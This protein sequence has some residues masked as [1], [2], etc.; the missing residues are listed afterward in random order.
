VFGPRQDPHGE[1]GVVAIFMNRLRGE[2]RPRIFGDG[3]Q[4]RDYVY[5]VDAADAALRALDVGGGVFNVGTGRETSVLELLE[6]IQHV[7]GTDVKPEFADPRPG[8]L[9]RSVLDVSVAAR[10]LGWRPQHDLDA[11]LAETWA[12]I[13]AA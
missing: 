12:W 8:E 2:A 7:A 10:E 9:Q 3:K 13:S 11:G 4:T 1:A 5:A 6:R